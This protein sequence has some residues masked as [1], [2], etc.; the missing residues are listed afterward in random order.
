MAR[1]R[2]LTQKDFIDRSNKIFNFKYDYSKVNYIDGRLKVKI[3]CLKHGE[4]EQQA[5][6]HLRG[7]GCPKCGKLE[8][9]KKMSLSQDTFIDRANQKHHN[10]YDY[11][12]VKYK[13]M[14]TK[15]TII[16]PLHKEFEQTPQHHLLGSGCPICNKSKGEIA[17][18]K[19]L[20][21]NKID[22]TPQKRFDTCK[23]TSLLPFDFYLTR[24]NICIEFDGIQHF[25]AIENWGGEK[26]LNETKIN[27]TIKTN[28]CKENNIKL[29]R[30]P[31]TEVKGI[32]NILSSKIKF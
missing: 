17:F 6:V 8:W 24:Y 20:L 15:I 11:S 1:F 3:I 18:A 23:N 31:Y 25:K 32:H 19:W 28:W 7:E 10:I 4:F 22:F 21:D 2:T 14:H 30:I 12:L 5:E 29:I 9:I 16:C 27:D 13:N 26:H